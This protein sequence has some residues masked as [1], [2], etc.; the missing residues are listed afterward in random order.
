MYCIEL[1]H[2]TFVGDGRPVWEVFMLVSL[3]HQC[4]EGQS[5]FGS[6]RFKDMFNDDEEHKCDR[7][8]L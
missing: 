8:V 6:Y 2:H 7:Y 5:R 3:S 4:L 1:V